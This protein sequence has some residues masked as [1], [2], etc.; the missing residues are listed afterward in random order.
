[1][2]RALEKGF[3]LD[4]RVIDEFEPELGRLSVERIRGEQNQKNK[5]ERVRVND[6]GEDRDVY[7]GK[8]T[9]GKTWP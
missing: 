5:I 3:Q 8:I 6:S 9:V 1:L 7:G 4:T 2:F